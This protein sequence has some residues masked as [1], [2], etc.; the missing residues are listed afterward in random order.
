VQRRRTEIAL[1]QAKEAADAANQAKSAFLANMSHEIRTPM[2]AII[3]FAHLLR[4]DPL[5]AR[6]QDHLGKIT[7]AGQHLLQVINDILDF[8]RSRPTRSRWTR[9]RLRRCAKAW[10]A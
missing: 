3:G 4:R 6:Q 7:D 5:S 8:S 1:G 2:N 10:S 9:G